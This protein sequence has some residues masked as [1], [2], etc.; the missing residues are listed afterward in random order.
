[1]IVTPFGDLDFKSKPMTLQWLAAHDI[2]HRTLRK[3]LSRRGST[4]MPAPLAA[5]PT[6]EWH[7]VHY[8]THMAL[9]RTTQPDPSIS[10]NTLSADPTDSEVLF[11][12]WHRM[13]NLL[14]QR[15]DQAL[16]VV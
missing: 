4:L 3:E 15:L 11:Y 16:Q 10:A 2:R 7:R 6:Q 12:N 1:M 8:L 5:K 13:H 14:H 9:L